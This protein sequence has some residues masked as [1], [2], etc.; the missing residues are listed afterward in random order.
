MTTA[1]D[2]ANRLPITAAMIL[3]ILM[4]T[5]DGAIANVALPH[6]HI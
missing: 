2:I 6:I 1:N 5:I 3:A 4:N